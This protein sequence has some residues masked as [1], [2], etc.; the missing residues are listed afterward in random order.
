MNG[1]V[2]K[3]YSKREDGE[4][5]VSTNFRVREFACQD[6][7]DAIVIADK[8]VQIL[9]SIRNHFGQP[10]TINSAYRTAAHNKKVGGSPTSQH[11]YGTAADIVVAGVYPSDVADYVELLMPNTGGIGRYRDFTHIDVRTKKSRFVG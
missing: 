6:G 7:S 3:V 1:A 8:L 11:L 2:C 4:K 5:K 9:Q 10:V